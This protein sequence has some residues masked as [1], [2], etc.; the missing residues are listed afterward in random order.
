[1]ERSSA[2][3]NQ[4]LW[5]P[6]YLQ[7]QAT[8]KEM[9]DNLEFGPGEKIPSERELSEQL[10]V[11]RMT[12]RRA[13]EKLV[14]QGALQRSSTRGTYVREPGVVRHIGSI[15]LEGLSQLLREEGAVPGSRLMSFEVTRAP[16]KV[17]ERLNMRVGEPLVVV[18]RLRLANGEP[19]C[20]ET[21][22]LPQ[23]M[24]PGLAAADLQE[25]ASLYEIL[26]QRYGIQP[27]GYEST[28][29]ISPA[30]PEEAALLGI[31][32]DCSIMMMRSV[33]HD[34]AGR[35]I[36]YLKSVNHPDRVVFRATTLQ[37]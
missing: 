16:R 29:S 30:T 22:Y 27:A 6:L 18:R 34:T 31:R 28:L 9:I 3:D 20:I 1:M 24:V 17:A 8:L 25:G 5:T 21:S 35:Q 32:P 11:S 23:A 26:A 2:R 12:V 19:F 13:V 10:G 14:E 4:R 37:S 15:P 36:E 7:V 33:V